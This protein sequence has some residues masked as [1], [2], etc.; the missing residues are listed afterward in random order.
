MI[1]HQIWWSLT[2]SL[3]VGD[4]ISWIVRHI[5]SNLFLDLLTGCLKEWWFLCHYTNVVIALCGCGLLINL[6]PQDWISSLHHLLLDQRA[7]LKGHSH[8][9]DVLKTAHFLFRDFCQLGD[10]CVGCGGRFFVLLDN[11]VQLIFHLVDLPVC[12]ASLRVVSY[13]CEIPYKDWRHRDILNW[14]PRALPRWIISVDSYKKCIC[15][16]KR[17]IGNLQLT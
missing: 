5:F 8:T 7:R 14:I 1:Y 9:F 10:L 2:K 12:W 17:G 11:A 6:G 13:R 4:Q 3:L 16:S 15:V